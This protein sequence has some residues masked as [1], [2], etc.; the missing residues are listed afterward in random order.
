MLVGSDTTNAG[1]RFQC[2]KTY[3]FVLIE[4]KIFFKAFVRKNW[5]SM[6]SVKMKFRMIK[7]TFSR[8][9]GTVSHKID[10]TGL[11]LHRD[12]PPALE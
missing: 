5:I 6:K 4:K 12:H 8:F 9:S 2:V 10:S 3:F 1:S 7:K 11:S